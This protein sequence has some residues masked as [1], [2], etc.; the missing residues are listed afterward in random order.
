M[1]LNQ[2]GWNDLLEKSLL[3]FA[4]A[5]LEAARVAVEHRG[6]YCVYSVHGQ[7]MAELSGKFRHEAGSSGDFPAVGDWLAVQAF[8]AEGKAIVHAVLPR[9]TKFSRTAAGERVEEQILA[10]NIDDVFIV[11]SLSAELN[12]RRIERYVTLAW[13]SGAEPIVVLTKADLCA[14]IQAAIRQ[15]QSAAYG[16]PVY[17]VSG[18][19]GQGME[20]LAGCLRPARTI[21]LLGPSGV[22]KSTLINYWCGEERLKV[23]PVREADQKGRHTTTQRQLICLPSGALIIDTPGMRELQLWEGE[24]GLAETFADIDAVAARCRF[25]DCKHE[26]EPDCAVRQAVESG[27]LD[28][29][30]LES[31]RK[32]KREW[33][34]FQRTQDKRAQAEE[35]RRIKSIMKGLRTLYK[36][37]Q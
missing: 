14:D 24:Q 19:T 37:Q 28:A 17:V 18:M 30:R 2:I 13:E 33:Q 32:L 8:P 27:E 7:L 6:G 29:E 36:E 5:G 16:V 4:Q 35:R 22:G 1:D 11:S 15:A 10:A 12:L 26:T 9:R 23:Q 34:Y 31:H 21:A 20:T 25:A 3:P